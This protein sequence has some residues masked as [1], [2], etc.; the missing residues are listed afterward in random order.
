[1]MAAMTAPM[2]MPVRRITTRYYVAPDGACYFSLPDV[3]SYL[4]IT[5]R[6]VR[7]LVAVG[8]LRTTPTNAGRPLIGEREIV[9]FVERS[10]PKTAKLRCSGA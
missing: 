2:I 9:A 3:A 4:G 5:R 8:E 10:F 1:M 7:D 6:Q